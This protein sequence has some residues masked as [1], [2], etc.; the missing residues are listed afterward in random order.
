MPT[1]ASQLEQPRSAKVAA[2]RRHRI[3]IIDDDDILAEVLARQLARQGF[4]A[5]TAGSGAA[6]LEKARSAHPD[7]IVLDLRLPDADGFSVCQ[8]LADASQTWSIPVIM[9]SGLEGPD[10]LRRCRAAGGRY[11]VRKPYDPNALLVLIRHAIHEAGAW[12]AWNC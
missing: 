12:D 3:L 1:S 4:D 11:F 9:L 10:I 2:R 5:I 6:G 7:L 8:E